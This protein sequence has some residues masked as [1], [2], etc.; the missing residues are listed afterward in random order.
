MNKSKLAAA[1]MALILPLSACSGV[2]SASA[3]PVAAA[4]QKSEDIPAGKVSLI[5]TG[6]LFTDRDSRTDYD[7]GGVTVSFGDDINCSEPERVSID[8]QTLTIKNEGTY[9][10]SGKLAN[11]S[12]IID[13]PND[14]KI[15][16]VLGGVE[17]Y[18]A[19]FAAI[20][21]KQ[22][23]KV[24]ITLSA[25]TENILS[26]GGS[27]ESLDENNVDA[28]IFSKDDLSFNGEGSLRIKSPA[29]NGVC[30]K[31]DLVFT[32]GTYTVTAEGHALEANDSVR[33]CGGSF[34]LDS[35]KDGIHCE[36]DGAEPGFVYIS[37]GS[38]DIL[39]DGDAI[40]AN[41]CVQLDGGTFDLNCGG[42]SS[43]VTQSG[44]EFKWSRPQNAESDDKASAKGIKSDM[45]I[46]VNAGEFVIDSA[47]D[48]LHASENLYVSGGKLTLSS[49]DDALHA[50]EKVCI[51]GGSL[52]ILKS[53]EGI[54]GR[55]VYLSGG[56][57]NVVSLDDGINAAG[58]R[59]QSGSGGYRGFGGNGAIKG[60][61]DSLISISGGTIHVNAN[62]DGLDSNGSVSVSGGDVFIDG[63]TNSGNSAL[64]YE[65]SAEITGGT[66]VAVGPAGMA[67]N[68][69]TAAQGV[70][71]LST[72]E[73]EAGSTVTVADGK[74]NVI[75]RYVPGKNYS[76]VVLSSA[77]VRQGETYTVTAG[78]YSAEITMD[79]FIYSEG[80]ASGMGIRPDGGKHGTPAGENQTPP[81][82][83][84]QM[85]SGGG[86]PMRPG[87]GPEK[88]G[89]NPREG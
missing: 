6:N 34:A 12:V 75:L 71:L 78:T 61:A 29:G 76:S 9:V 85:P 64:D 40:S 81:D 23:D 80:G 46:A 43:T 57:I 53:Y 28:V 18:S 67:Q 33:I 8:G 87:E 69:G 72:L 20:Y 2:S 48:S 44:D 37:G 13:A 52:D 56:D 14:A 49:G 65:L 32:G 82:G 59:D 36:N 35:G 74:G 42:G 38:F 58:G 5:E 55:E 11:G 16:L 50:D 24:F 86:K 30:S 47:D 84:N 79:S 10:L 88:P 4:V 39:S 21:V 51:S 66:L 89:D 41:G 54:E 77:D 31:D 17:I 22:A 63:P 27:F 83:E 68:F 19:D 1:V 7:D 25:G 3:E 70:M 45:S 62:G 15:Q 60:D 26:N 73:Q